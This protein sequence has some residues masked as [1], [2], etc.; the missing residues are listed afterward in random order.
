VQKWLVEGLPEVNKKTATVSQER[1]LAA[2]AKN[3]QQNG[4]INKGEAY[5]NNEIIKLFYTQI[6]SEK[7]ASGERLV[8]YLYRF[9]NW[10]SDY[11]QGRI[12]RGKSIGKRYVSDCRTK[13][14]LHIE[15]FFR[16]T[17][18]CDVTTSML[19]RFMMSFP[20]RDGDTKNGYARHTINLIM[21]VIKKP[22]KDAVRLGVIPKNPADG[23]DLLCN[24]TRERGI[25]TPEE[26]EK[27]F[28]C[29]WLDERSKVASIVAA[30]S[31]MR[32]GE[33]AALQIDDIDVERDII[34]VRH[35][36]SPREKRLKNPKNGKGRIIYTDKSIIQMLLT[37]H[38]KNPYKGSFI[39]WG[40]APNKPM[41]FET[42]EHDLEKALAALLG[43]AAKQEMT[44]EWREM[45]CILAIKGK[46]DQDEIIALTI[47]DLD[48]AQNS[49]HIRHRYAYTSKKLKIDNAVGKENTIKLDSSLLKRISVICSKN[50]YAF[51]FWGK[52]H[53]IDNDETKIHILGEVI[54][55]ERNI[56]FHGFR[57][58]FNSTI[59][60]TVSDDILRLQTG[61]L[62]SKMT[63]AYDHMT[64]D[65]G[66]QLR[67]A[68][69]SKILPFIK[70]VAG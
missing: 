65:R 30:V 20:R 62:D 28:H 46:L 64:D 10:D 3:L 69:R 38:G 24:D 23:V 12:E 32:L 57:H 51:V 27:L 5:E 22:L 35:S 15:P 70:D 68:V 60:G 31:G 17:L 41:R 7:M 8:D 29:K 42:I 18:L 13:I 45:A 2:I 6:T 63:D 44:Q 39:F 33:I 54:R 36:Y 49:V 26:L 1:L 37:L 53:N 58:F 25:L 40:L 56:S 21:K 59:R 9:W 43:K 67:K 14:K 4:R 48:T 61:H 11:V 19:E 52:D 55:R 16:D 50:P 66:E 47:T 34:Y